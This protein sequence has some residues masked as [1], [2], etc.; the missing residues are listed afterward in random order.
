MSTL[1]ITPLGFAAGAEV[2]GIDLRKPLDAADRLR[3]NEA[4]LRHLVLVFPRQELTPQEQIVFARNFGALDQHESQAPQTLHADHHEILVL[5]NK[6][7]GGKQSGT[8]NSGRNWHTDLSYTT[9]PAKG[10]L[11]HCKEKPPVGGDTMFANLYIAYE[12]LSPTMRKLLESLEALHDVSL[13]RGIEQRDPALVADMK[14]RNP[15][16]IHPVVRVHPETGRK[17]LF[18]GQRI[19]GFLGVSDEE[20]QSLLAMLNAHATSPEFVYRHRW[21]VGDLLMWDNRCSC[22][23]A[24]G[25]FDQ[26]KPR[27]MYRCSLQGQEVTGRFATEAAAADRDQMLQAVAA[28]S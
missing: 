3:I 19:R 7:V 1:T 12:T 2:T 14:R 18:V 5:T 11:L 20:S 23:V 26:T 27:V 8:H 22:H 17:S 9:C 13:I 16:V 4:W 15:P 6:L 28:V 21:S 10:A 24:L 25:D